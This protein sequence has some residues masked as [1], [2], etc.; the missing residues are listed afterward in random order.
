MLADVSGI[1][2]QC[3]GGAGDPQPTLFVQYDLS[4]RLDVGTGCL[5]CA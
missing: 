3:G 1:F 2:G 5:Y 4:A